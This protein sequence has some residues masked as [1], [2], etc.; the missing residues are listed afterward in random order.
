MKIYESMNNINFGKIS[1]NNKN[2]NIYVN[3]VKSLKNI[4]IPK[5]V[6]FAQKYTIIKILL[7]F[8][9]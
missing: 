1:L 2:Q 5:K 7:Y 9:K 3:K 8:I 4:Y 6:A